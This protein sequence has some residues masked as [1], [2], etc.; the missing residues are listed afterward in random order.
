MNC[1]FRNGDTFHIEDDARGQW[2]PTL[3]T[4]EILL[5]QMERY[6]ELPRT[7]PEL[8]EYCRDPS[9]VD[10]DGKFKWRGGEAVFRFG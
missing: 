3:A 9:W 4:M 7:A 10:E 2:S 1:L 6:S 5:E 8:H